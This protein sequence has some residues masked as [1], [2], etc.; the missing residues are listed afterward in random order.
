MAIYYI[1]SLAGGGGSGSFGSPW[2]IA[3]FVSNHVATNEYRIMADGPY[4][5]SANITLTDGTGGGQVVMRVVG[6]NAS[7]V[8][9]GTRPVLTAASS[10]TKMFDVTGAYGL[11]LDLLDLNCNGVADYGL[12]MNTGYTGGI[13]RVKV[14]A[15]KVKGILTIT[16]YAH[17][18]ECE[19]TGGI[20]GATCGVD[21]SGSMDRCWV[22]DN[23]CTGVV[24]A[25]GRIWK[26]RITKN[27]GATSDGVA[28][29]FGAIV[30]DCTIHGNGRHGVH[31]T[32][33][34]AI[35]IGARG[36]ILTGNGGY[37]LAAPSLNSFPGQF[38]WD[39]NAYYSN[40][41]GSRDPNVGTSNGE[42]VTL[43]GLPYV[44]AGTDDYQ[45][46]N[47]AGQGAACRLARIPGVLPGGGTDYAD[48]GA[49]QHPDPVGGGGGTVAYV[50]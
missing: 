17:V 46:N 50:F 35:N 23:A 49:M 6:A 14:S 25:S 29:S 19:V 9:D 28:Y 30:S 27:T 48:L 1:S 43:S 21:L 11:F 45:L 33:P 15:F 40:T 10:C 18:I 39:N 2:T 31:I 7:G 36:N 20:S 3:E 41:S 5:I 13:T 22:H 8:I 16:N 38:A 37:G 42:D 4:T 12:Y 47:T 24:I 44:N 26:S 34:Y 32:G